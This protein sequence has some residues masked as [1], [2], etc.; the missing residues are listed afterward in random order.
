MSARKLSTLETGGRRFLYH[1]LSAL[2]A[3]EVAKLPYCRKILLENILRTTDVSGAE[4]GLL[5]ALHG[6]KELEF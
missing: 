5:A 2:D 1:D 4:G 6:E 3:T